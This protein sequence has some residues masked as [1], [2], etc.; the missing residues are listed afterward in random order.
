[1]ITLRQ[2]IKQ[3]T[4]NHFTMNGLNNSSLRED[5]NQIDLLVETN[6]KKNSRKKTSTNV[7]KRYF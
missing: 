2:R 6:E 5:I 3:K 7:V 4:Y 1:M